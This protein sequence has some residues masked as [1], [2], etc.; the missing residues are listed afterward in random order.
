MY[1][2]TFSGSFPG[3][4]W[5]REGLETCAGTPKL[6]A[7]NRSVCQEEFEL[8]HPVTSL[9]GF[10]GQSINI[11]LPASAAFLPSSISFFSHP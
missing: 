4:R 11:S 6:Q 3:A 2:L 5:S 1:D 7:K 9:S 10:G 8:Q